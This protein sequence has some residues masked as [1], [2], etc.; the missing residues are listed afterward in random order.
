MQFGLKTKIVITI[1]LGL[2]DFCEFLTA[3]LQKKCGTSSKLP[4]KE[5]MR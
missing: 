2:D 3:G 5:L 4:M 1:A